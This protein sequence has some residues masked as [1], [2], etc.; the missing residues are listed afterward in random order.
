MQN[1]C[2][3]Q[4]N[5]GNA[6]YL[7]ELFN[8]YQLQMERNIINDGGK[9]AQFDYKNIVTVG[10]R[11]NAFEW[12]TNFIEAEKDHLS[13]SV[14][15]T[16]YN[17]NLARLYFSQ[18]RFREALR[19]LLMVE[20]TDVY[21]ELDSRSLLLKTYYELEEY[22]AFLSLVSS[23]GLFLRRNKHVSEY[24]RTVYR[25]L[26]RFSRKLFRIK[27]GGKQ[28][29]GKVANEMREV[30]QIADLTWL[31]QKVAELVPA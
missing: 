25:N 16:A 10:L 9:I 29:P 13:E 28:A 4:A 7:K 27:M 21:Y 31:N 11:V 24:Q 17:Y 18:N 6:E 23:F 26:I 20:Y 3:K 15:D 5:Q 14:R 1:Y 2:I 12:I 22:E 30:K 19:A 8:L